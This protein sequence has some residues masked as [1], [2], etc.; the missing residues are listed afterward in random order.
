[1]VKGI[2]KVVSCSD[3][4]TLQKNSENGGHFKKRTLVL[5]ELGGQYEDKFVC[6]C[7]GNNAECAFYEND[8]V[9]AA[10]RFTTSNHEGKTYQDV[11]AT[12]IIK[13]QN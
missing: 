9:Y 2:F 12:E 3:V 10:I 7:L 8:L 13:I 1:M 5:Q 6:S 4:F 11:L